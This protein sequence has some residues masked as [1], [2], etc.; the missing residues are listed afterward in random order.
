MAKESIKFVELTLSGLEEA[1]TLVSKGMSYE[2]TKA[3]DGT[4]ILIVRNGTGGNRT[5]RLT[6]TEEE[7][8]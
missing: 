7:I 3:T 6:I 4:D 8:L 1:L 5:F 2:I